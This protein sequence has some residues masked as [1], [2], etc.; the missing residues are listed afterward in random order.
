MELFEK[1][2]SSEMKF[3]GNV[4]SLREDLVQLP[5]N[6]T[7]KREVVQ[8]NGAVGIV[9]LNE[10]NEIVLVKQF[11]AGIRRVTLELPAGKLE[12]GEEPLECG[13][14]ELEEET[15]YKANSFKKLVSF[16]TSPAIL[17]EIIHI[18]LASDLYEG[19]T[20]PDEDEFVETVTV[21]LNQAKKL[22]STGEIEDG[23]TIIGIF[24]ALE[25]L[26]DLGVDF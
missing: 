10:N 26:K 2:I 9:A 4:L 13:K 7:S 17:E 11:R 15:G 1:L 6:S 5:N 14:R 22:I 21:S 3:K 24:L 16:A 8:H 19:K 18:F 25:H 23:K 20:N 12:L